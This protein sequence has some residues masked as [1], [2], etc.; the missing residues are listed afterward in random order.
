MVSGSNVACFKVVPR[1]V[2][3]S[4]RNET[5]KDLFDNVVLEFRI[6]FG[7][8]M[9]PSLTIKSTEAWNILFLSSPLKGTRGILTIHCHY[10]LNTEMVEK[11]IRP[12]FDIEVGTNQEGTHM[13]TNNTV[14][15][16]YWSILMRGI[17]SS[18]MYVIVMIG[19]D[20]ENIRIS[21]LEYSSPSWSIKTY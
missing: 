12:E 2:S 9:D 13:V 1:D 3:D 14:S 16:L 8:R 7:R 20:V 17:S 19:K 6:A 15:L 5:K 10:I 21:G 18:R 4:S 11:F